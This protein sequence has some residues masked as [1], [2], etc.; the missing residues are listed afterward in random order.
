M[1]KVVGVVVFA[2]VFGVSG[3]D[4]KAQGWQNYGTRSLATGPC[5]GLSTGPCR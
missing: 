3:N 5:G 1:L 4:A 2:V